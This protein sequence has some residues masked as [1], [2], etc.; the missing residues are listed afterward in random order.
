MIPPL[1][2]LETLDGSAKGAGLVDQ[3]QNVSVGDMGGR[4]QQTTS[5][6]QVYQSSRRD[7]TSSVHHQSSF[8]SSGGQY[9][10]GGANY[11]DSL[12]QKQG[13]ASLLNTWDTN[14]LYLDQ[15]FIYLLFSSRVTFYI[16]IQGV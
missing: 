15:V 11:S 13:N 1:G 5:Q 12:Y 16:Y 2:G 7:F 10:Q 4:M 14:K 9:R 3:N 8:Y 6:Q